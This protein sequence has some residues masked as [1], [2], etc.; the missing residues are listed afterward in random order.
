VVISNCVI[1]LSTD[2]DSVLREAFRV[3]R[4]GGKF[5][6]SDIDMAAT[7]PPGSLPEGVTPAR[8]DREP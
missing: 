8:G 5:A 7:L 3:L 6:V 1:D 4:P 2:R